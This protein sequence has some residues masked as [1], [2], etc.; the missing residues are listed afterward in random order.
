MTMATCPEVP[1]LL[2]QNEAC[3]AALATVERKIF[4][5]EESYFNETPSGNLMKGFDLYSDSREKGVIDSR[6]KG[7]T[8]MDPEL[9]WF[10]YSSY[11][12]S[13]RLLSEED[14]VAPVPAA[15]RSHKK[16]DPSSAVA[17]DTA[18]PKAR[19]AGTSRKKKRRRKG[20]GDSDNTDDDE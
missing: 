14:N 1:A 8:R 12:S 2:K 11:S 16:K 4:E 7:V 13:K 19:S 20:P 10:T 15:S 17:K 3:A 6:K 5:L 18:A 9:R